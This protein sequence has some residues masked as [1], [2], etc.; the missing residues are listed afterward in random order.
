M[1]GANDQTDG[2]EASE[3]EGEDAGSTTEELTPEAEAEAAWAE[4]TGTKPESDEDGDGSGE[5]AGD[6]SAAG[7]GQDTSDT[8]GD[9]PSEPAEGEQS[10]EAGE[11]EGES[12]TDSTDGAGSDGDIWANAP[13]ELRDAF[14]AEK[15]RADRAEQRSASDRG[16]VSALQTR[17]DTLAG[18][19][20]EQHDKAGAAETSPDAG[21]SQDESP[22]ETDE[23]KTVREEFGDIVEPIEKV[24]KP[25]VTDLKAVKAE[26]QRLR[27]G[28]QTIGQDRVHSRVL[29]QEAQVRE[30]HPDYDDIVKSDEFDAWAQ[31]APSYIRQGLERNGEAIVDAAEASDLIARFKSDTGYGSNGETEGDGSGSSTETGAK[32]ANGAKANGKDG[33]GSKPAAPSRRRQI[34]LDSAS[35]PRSKAGEAAVS[36][37]E[38]ETEAEMWDWAVKKVRSEREAAI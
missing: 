22:F 13:S 9:P 24:L 11:G 32:D 31:A 8:D 35:A 2:T 38:P 25:F 5:E 1:S 37:K 17:L 36:D 20:P 10:S 12:S 16:R 26:N 18:K 27:D 34:Q 21:D 4:F 28:M 15:S 6:T 14:D 30:D 33:D 29:E 3:T 19:A 7:S 23:W